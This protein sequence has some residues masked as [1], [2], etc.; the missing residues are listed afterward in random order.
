M[1]VSNFTAVFFYPLQRDEKHWRTKSLSIF[2][3]L[4]VQC[5]YVKFMYIWEKMLTLE[6]KKQI[7]LT[8]KSKQTLTLVTKTVV[9]E[10]DENR[11][12]V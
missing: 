12:K 6:S 4:M 1:K 5:E 7:L 2:D 3:L 11:G 8:L 10:M 9:N